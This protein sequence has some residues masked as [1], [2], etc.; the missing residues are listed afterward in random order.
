MENGKKSRFSKRC[1][2]ARS[3]LRRYNERADFALIS[4]MRYIN[5]WGLMRSS[6]EE[7][8]QE[9]SHMVAVLPTL[10]LIAR[11]IF[12]DVSAER[13]AVLALYHDASETHRRPAN[14]EIY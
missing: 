12:K 14:P 6:I 9:H 2:T 1:R 4:R 7:N 11:E 3:S 8:V 13:L 5:R 10:R